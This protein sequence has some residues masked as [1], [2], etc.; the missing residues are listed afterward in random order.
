[1]V[2][3][4]V[5]DPTDRHRGRLMAGE[6]QGHNGQLERLVGQRFAVWFA[7][8]NERRQEVLPCAE[9]IPAPRKQFVQEDVAALDQRPGAAVRAER[10]DREVEGAESSRTDILK[11]GIE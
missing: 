3:Q 6:E 1:M 7:M 2:G 9:L 5:R 4:E 10:Q 11:D 8:P